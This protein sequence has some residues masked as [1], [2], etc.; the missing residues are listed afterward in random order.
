MSVAIEPVAGRVELTMA[1]TGSGVARHSVASVEAES[2][3][4]TEGGRVGRGGGYSGRT[5]T[6]LWEWSDFS[7]CGG[8]APVLPDAVAPADICG[9]FLSGGGT[10]HCAPLHL[11]QSLQ[12]WQASVLSLESLASVRCTVSDFHRL[13]SAPVTHTEDAASGSVEADGDRARGGGRVVAAAAPVPTGDDHD[14]EPADG[15]SSWGAGVSAVR[16]LPPLARDGYRV[17]T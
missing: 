15:G 7:L 17:G 2:T 12:E 1:R 4:L 3:P 13:I 6:G 5:H 10:L 14:D 8:A 11:L 9:T 16:R